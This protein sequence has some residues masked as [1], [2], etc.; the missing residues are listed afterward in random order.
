[1]S[2]SII[3]VEKVSVFQNSIPILNHISWYVE[4]HQHWILFGPNGSGKTT[5]LRL[6]TGN[7]FPTEGSIITLGET[8]GKTDVWA[9][10]RKIGW[11]SNA[12][13]QLIHGEDPAIDIVL[14]GFFAGTRLWF[15]VTPEQ[16]EMAMNILQKLDAKRFWDKPFE[17]LSQGEK[18]RVLLAR[19]L[20]MNPKL[21]ILDEPCEGLDLAAR[22][23]FLQ[24]LSTLIQT[25]RDL[26]ILFVTHHIEEIPSGFNYIFFLDHGNMFKQGKI[27][28][29]L[30]SESLSQL[31]HLDL[32]VVQQNNRYFCYLNGL[33]DVK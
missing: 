3:S 22:E 15:D 13:D 21:L 28:D 27:S 7:L 19:A 12:L 23:S 29:I 2:N 26:N 10:N 5:L 17:L 18:K 6:I 24:L 8:I 11:I 31:F 33:E 16:R 4:N 25:E 14:S 32:K 20:V 1:M 9:L 30:T